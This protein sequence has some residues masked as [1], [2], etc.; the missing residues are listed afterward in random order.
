MIEIQIKKIADALDIMV[1][2]YPKGGGIE[3]YTI[4]GNLGRIAD[5]LESIAASLESLTKVIGRIEG[6]DQFIRTGE[7]FRD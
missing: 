4:G 6:G 2:G 3:A 5:A 1:N 7:L